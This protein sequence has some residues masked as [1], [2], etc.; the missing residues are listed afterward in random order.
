M[1][2]GKAPPRYDV[3]L[4][5]AGE[6]RQYVERVAS[7]L[8]ERGVRSFY[9]LHE[10]VDLWGKDL[11]QH[12]AEVY[13]HWGR[14]CIVFLSA[15]YA[16]KLWPRHELRSAQARALE[17]QR[18]YVL[19]ARFD[20]TE[21]PGVFPTTGYIDLRSKTPEELAE[22]IVRKLA[23]ASPE[24]TVT[25]PP[26]ESG[27]AFRLTTRLGAILCVAIGLVITA[28]LV[29]F[30]G[31][32]GAGPV[33]RPSP[34]LA[35]SQG[36]KGRGI[37]QAGESPLESSAA[38]APPGSSPGAV[39]I[40]DKVPQQAAADSAVSGQ[41][42]QEVQG[43]MPS[44]KESKEL[45]V[46]AEQAELEIVAHDGTST[47]LANPSIAY[48]GGFGPSN[49]MKGIAVRRGIEEGILLWSEVSV[50][51]FRSRQE[52]N[53]KGRIIWRHSI[54]AILVNGG[55]VHAELKDDWNM[56]Y[57]GGGGTGLLH[58]RTDLGEVHI[59]FS[60][61]ALLKV[62][63][64]V[65]PASNDTTA[66]PM[67]P[68]LS[69]NDTDDLSGSWSITVMYTTWKIDLERDESKE[70]G[71]DSPVYCGWITAEENDRD[72]RRQICAAKRS[73]RPILRLNLLRPS[74]ISCE[75]PFKSEGTME[76]RCVPASFPLS[77]RVRTS[78]SYGNYPFQAMRLPKEG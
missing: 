55:V 10:E 78:I 2:S 40:E 74:V 65:R 17:E 26:Q 8:A 23:H 70:E 3:C 1:G 53:E 48:S 36:Q 64:Y 41:E 47:V 45:R 11:Y 62:R 25:L 72:V 19:P 30:V 18:E 60:K 9:D 59:P 46:A 57:M 61:I 76:G 71:N 21:I 38:P 27:K 50:I 56:A 32:G 44:L 4:S 42:A 63:K 13:Q 51:R 58:G 15:A 5:F 67:G 37:I 12:L 39:Q 43:A 33:N 7:A 20:D 22:L 35:S 28:L 14:Y 66:R 68:T 73:Y 6:D 34:D 52:E 77:S 54:E 49:M 75:A 16:A 69:T 29:Y 24:P 31:A